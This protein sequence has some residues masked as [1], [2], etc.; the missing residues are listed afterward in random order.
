MAAR[1]AVAAAV[2]ITH[3]T[4]KTVTSNHRLESVRQINV[5]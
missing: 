1:I 4:L 3:D 2:A 5:S